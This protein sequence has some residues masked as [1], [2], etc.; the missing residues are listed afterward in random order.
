MGWF[1]SLIRNDRASTSMGSVLAGAATCLAFSPSRSRPARLPRLLVRGT[2]GSLL[3]AQPHALE[4]RSY[5]GRRPVGRLEH[6]AVGARS[7]A[8]LRNVRSVDLLKD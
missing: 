1:G 2:V 6:L 3:V 8:D 7:A 5:L 4:E